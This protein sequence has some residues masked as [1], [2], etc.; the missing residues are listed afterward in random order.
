MKFSDFEITQ[1]EIMLHADGVELDG[2]LTIPAHASGLVLFIHGSGSSRF[3]TR[4]RYVAELLNQ[5][6]LATILFDL[7]TAEENEIDIVTREYRFDIPLLSRRTIAA[8]QSVSTRPDL[9]SLPIGLFGASTG[10]AAALFAAK[11]LPNHI[12]AVVSRG[13]RPDLA[14]NA[15]PDVQAPTLLIVGGLD[16]EVL[17]L[18]KMAQRLLQIES[19][20]TII[21][22]ATHLFEEPG[23]LELAANAAKE[24]F[25]KKLK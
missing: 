2:I 13:G 18:N 25:L 16:Y 19:Q 1:K 22:G 15:L 24:W 21:P 7:L 5:A 9:A 10:A 20:I 14:K 8:I 6:S 12:S 23:T 3:S 17:A 11:A 4:N